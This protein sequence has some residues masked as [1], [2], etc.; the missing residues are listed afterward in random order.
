MVHLKYDATPA[1]D[2]ER[3]KAFIEDVYS[4]VPLFLGR[5]FVP[6]QEIYYLSN[7]DIGAD[8]LYQITHNFNAQMRFSAQMRYSAAGGPKYI[9]YGMHDVG[10]PYIVI[11]GA[12]KSNTALHEAIHYNGV[13]DERLTRWLT[14]VYYRR[15]AFNLGLLRRPVKY[16]MVPVSGMELDGILAELRLHKPP[17]SH[18]EL[19]HLKYIPE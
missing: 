10:A 16:E 18:V 3:M 4:R 5:P 11:S 7:S 15:A 1:N 19:V 17:N 8:R 2:A 12:P 6:P 14:S 9:I 13:H